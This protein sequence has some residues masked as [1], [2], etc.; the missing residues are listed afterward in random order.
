MSIK[1]FNIY[2]EA[3]KEID[4][5]VENSA[6]KYA[7]AH[8]NLIIDARLGWYSVPHSFKVY[9]TVDLEES[10]KR[11]LNDENRGQVEQYLDLEHAKSEIAERFKLE[12]DRWFNIYNV[13]KD[14]M[15]NYDYV[16]DTTNISPEEASNNILEKYFK[17][18][19][20]QDN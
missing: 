1:E 15:S 9:L 6:Q 18:L 19:E 20:K 16:L 5:E 17:W 3:H 10:A 4:L 12:N 8:D 13:R 7:E 2:V 14:D 11:I